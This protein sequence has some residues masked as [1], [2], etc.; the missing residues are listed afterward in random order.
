M[1]DFI[2]TGIP[3]FIL[4]AIAGAII[5]FFVARKNPKW[6]EDTYQAQ[7]GLSM[8]GTEKIAELEKKIADLELDKKIEEKAKEL[9]AKAGVKV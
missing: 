5:M 3:G 2:V 7:R 9:L 8:Q 6:V 4:G 1:I